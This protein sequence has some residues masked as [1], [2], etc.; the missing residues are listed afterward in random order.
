MGWGVTA[1]ILHVTALVPLLYQVK[2]PMKSLGLNFESSVGEGEIS[3][4]KLKL[5]RWVRFL[6]ERIENEGTD[7]RALDGQEDVE[8]EG[9]EE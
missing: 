9:P 6:R 5:W 2:I 7:H 3:M 8:M 1:F 4:W